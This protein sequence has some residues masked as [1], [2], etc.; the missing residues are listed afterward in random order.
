MLEELGY[1]MRIFAE[2]GE[3]EPLTSADAGRFDDIAEPLNL[4]CRPARK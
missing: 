4:V 2:S 1:S 3:G